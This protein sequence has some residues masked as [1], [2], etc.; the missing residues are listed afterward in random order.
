MDLGQ[1]L[2]L[3]QADIEISMMRE[4]RAEAR[5]DDRATRASEP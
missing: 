3:E 2:A 5:P 4:F 1:T